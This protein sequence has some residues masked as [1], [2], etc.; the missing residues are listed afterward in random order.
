[1]IES[2]VPSVYSVGVVDMVTRRHSIR[3]PTELFDG[4]EG[5]K[6]SNVGACFM[7]LRC[8]RLINKVRSTLFMTAHDETLSMSALTRRLQCAKGDPQNSPAT[9]DSMGRIS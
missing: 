8:N 5:T 9:L 2:S 7:M 6:G 3:I 1:M 4:F